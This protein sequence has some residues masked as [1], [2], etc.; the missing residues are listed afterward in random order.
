MIPVFDNSNKFNRLKTSNLL[1]CILDF[2]PISDWLFLSKLDKKFYTK[3]KE[4]EIFGGFLLLINELNTSLLKDSKN[5]MKLLENNATQLTN[6]IDTHEILTKDE[7][8]LQNIF[9]FYFKKDRKID[10]KSVDIGTKGNALLS[11]FL[12]FPA[13][14]SYSLLGSYQLTSKNGADKLIEVLNRSKNLNELGLWET[15]FNEQYATGFNSFISVHK[16]LTKLILRKNSFSTDIL[17]LLFVSLAAN[18]TLTELTLY[19]NILKK[20]DCKVLATYLQSTKYLRTFKL[21]HNML[22]NECF[23]MLCTGL[24]GD[25][26]L[27]Y[28]DFAYNHVGRQGIIALFEVMNQ[29]SVKFEE[30]NKSI[31]RLRLD[32][33][34]INNYPTSQ[35]IGELLMNNKTLQHLHINNCTL[36]G[37]LIGPILAAMGVNDTLLTLD[38]S[39]NYIGPPGCKIICEG[40]KVN[41]SVRTLN[42]YDTGMDED[43]MQEFI[44]MIKTQG[45]LEEIDLRQDVFNEQNKKFLKEAFKEIKFIF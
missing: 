11:I 23:G 42:L 4:T 22:D 12:D 41:K 6:F 39:E 45:R 43:F 18:K 24:K 32:H 16:N 33:L 26:T 27:E 44:D 10:L 14:A 8:M 25:I 30:A 38:L 3:I 15:K 28:F 36:Y 20:D 21:S 40:L 34:L 37:N 29:T 7:K 17:H 19:A 2:F 9:Y 31:K 13:T 35:L 1:K 5:F